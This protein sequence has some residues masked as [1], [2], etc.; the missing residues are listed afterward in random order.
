MAADPLPLYLAS[1]SPRRRDILQRL[2]VQFKVLNAPVKELDHAS[3]GEALVMENAVRKA[4]MGHLLRPEGRILAADTVVA[5]GPRLFNKPRDLEE[6]REM[7]QALSGQTHEVLTALALI[8]PARNDEERRTFALGRSE[9]TFR[10]FDQ[11][12]IER[13][14]HSINPLDKAGAYAIQEHRQLIIQSWKGSFFNIMGLPVR[15]TLRLLFHHQIPSRLDSST[16][17]D[18]QMDSDE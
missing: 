3:T 11:D 6:A 8:D 4:E 1:G 14:L 15:E 9:I 7:L 10:P 12:R 5:L 16:F 17:R 13:Y 18:R 2:K